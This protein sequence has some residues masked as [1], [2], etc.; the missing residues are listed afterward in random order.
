MII[1]Y[2]IYKKIKNM[3][4]YNNNLK[5]SDLNKITNV[6]VNSANKNISN[7][8]YKKNLLKLS[9][10]KQISIFIEGLNVINK[11]LNKVILN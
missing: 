4:N 9:N 8:D 5:N 11:H 7:K 10:K 6:S 2:H 1:K 3:T